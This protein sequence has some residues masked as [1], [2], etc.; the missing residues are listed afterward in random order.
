M[1]KGFIKKFAAVFT[2]ATMLSSLGTAAFAANYNGTGVEIKSVNVVQATKDGSN[3]DDVFD[4]TVSYELGAGVTNSIGVTMLAYTG[5]DL[6]VSDSA[7]TSYGTGM[8][9]VGVDQQTQ[10]GQTGSFSFRVT[11]K[12]EEVDAIKVAYN[13]PSIV[14]VSGDK[15][16]P[17]AAVFTVR[18]PAWQADKATWT[19]E[20]SFEVA[21]PYDE[22]AIKTAIALSISKDDI[23]L[24]KDGTSKETNFTSLGTVS[25]DNITLKKNGDVY[26]A[27]FIFPKNATVDNAELASA[28]T[29]VSIG[30]IT[31]TKEAWTITSTSYGTDNSLTIAHQASAEAVRSAI[32]TVL[33][34]NGVTVKGAEDG[35]IKTI[36][37]YTLGELG[38]SYNPESEEDQTVTAKV[39]VDLADET[40][41]AGSG[42]AL[43][44]TLTVTVKSA[45]A[46]KWDVVSATMS[47]DSIVFDDQETTVTADDLLTKVTE[48]VKMRSAVLKG[49]NA[50]EEE[51][52]SL[53]GATVVVKDAT[54][55]TYTVTIPAGTST[56][57][58]KIE[59][60]Y[61][62]DITVT[63]NKKK[64][65]VV[66]GDMNNDNMWTMADAIIVIQMGLNASN[67]NHYAATDEEKIK[68]D[69]N[70][71]N[72]FT[73][74]DAILI[75]QRGLNSSNANH[76]DKF[77]VEESK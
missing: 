7:Y 52:V 38:G 32:Q 55:Y 25:A 54:A 49:A 33:S 21:Y 67:S 31:I 34:A 58:A 11:T 14:L 15:V 13:T 63:V 71:D 4:I 23:K 29:T 75:I 8:Q 1:K 50:G 72:I 39:T 2:A 45:S 41:V 37:E 3:I 56:S 74:A 44:F 53:A 59:A 61:S 70:G 77:P 16:T 62:F 36:K 48:E 10:S 65:A 40:E 66:Y 26:S 42:E 35:M 46:A 68:A 28:L 27:E 22:A 64:P 43:E 12:G 24:S 9:I 51:T 47:G 76:I 20:T 30:E 18:E 60:D 73:M 69:V 17:A 6:S 19:G 5:S 57:L